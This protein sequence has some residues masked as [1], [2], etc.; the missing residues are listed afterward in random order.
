MRILS[1]LNVSNI[2]DIDCDSGVI[3]QRLLGG[4]VHEMGGQLIVAGPQHE[5]FMKADLGQVEK[6]FIQ[7]GI[8]RFSSRFSFDWNGFKS[9]VEESRPDLILCCQ[10][11]AAAAIRAVLLESRANI[12]LL[13]YCHYPN[14][15]QEGDAVV[16]DSGFSIVSGV[17]A[18]AVVSALEV[19]DRFFIQSRFARS[20][21]TRYAPN[22]P[23]AIEV[24]PPPADPALFVRE[25]GAAPQNRRVLFNH[26][27]YDSYGTKDFIEFVRSNLSLNLE[28]VI[29][30]PMA[31]RSEQRTLFNNS[32]RKNLEAMTALGAQ[33][34]DGTADRQKYRSTIESCRVAV[35]AF[36]RTC[37]WSM[38][39]VDCMSMGVPVIAP[40]YA[41][42][43]EFVPKLLRFYTL[44][45]A[46]LL[47][48]RLLDDDSFWLE[49]S[50]SVRSR[51]Q[52]LR[53]ESF[54]DA[55]LRPVR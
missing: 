46:T 47:L 53:P 36:R 27:L 39:V 52:V 37:V 7:I 16:P 19:S 4:A 43:G 23:N 33:V 5:N 3:V 6:R 28:L 30:N 11:E 13:T 54:L 12:S 20:L 38:S 17:A 51:S 22:V 10:V 55:I 8:D 44:D 40:S 2:D 48:Q 18:S 15:V 50:A 29:A 45:E 1:Y 31:N 35:A 42:Y 32:P 26:R 49:A 14:L 21:I 34:H 25:R 9:V 41:A 24:V